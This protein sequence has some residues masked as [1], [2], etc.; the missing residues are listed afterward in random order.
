MSLLRLPK[1][2]SAREKIAK[3]KQQGVNA[4][5]GN[6][7]TADGVYARVGYC[8]LESTILVLFFEINLFF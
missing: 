8:Y 4:T 5:N 3:G 2:L 1:L 6:E 7:Y